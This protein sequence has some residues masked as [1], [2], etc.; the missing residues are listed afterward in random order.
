MAARKTNEQ[1]LEEARQAVNRAK[2]R[3]RKIK[4]RIETEERKKRNHTLILIAAE[5]M[6]FFDEETKEYLIAADDEA[7]KIWVKVQMQKIQKLE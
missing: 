2:L 1:M 5:M 4:N 6:T 3:E 7:V